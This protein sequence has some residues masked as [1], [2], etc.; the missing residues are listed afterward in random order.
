MNFKSLG[1]N[2]FEVELII[3]FYLPRPTIVLLNILTFVKLKLQSGAQNEI[4]PTGI[5]AEI[6][7]CEK[8]IL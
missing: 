5:I 6:N 1:L 3:E 7:E 8:L 4:S 2:F